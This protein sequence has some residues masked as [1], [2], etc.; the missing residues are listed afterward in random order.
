VLPSGKRHP[1]QRRIPA[2]SLA[3]AG[4]GLLAADLTGCSSFEEL[5]DEVEDMV[6]DIYMIGPLVIYDVSRRIGAY[7]GLEPSLV[8][9]HSG[10]RH[11][12]R[13]LGL[14]RGR[15][16][17]KMSELPRELHRLSAAEGEDFLCIY[18]EELAVLG[19]RRPR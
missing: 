3:A 18:T 2:A 17:L 10:T 8:Y 15:P 5:H 7:L 13:A 19:R 4:R 11:G 9:L 14:G 1:H 16:T 12:A 6:G